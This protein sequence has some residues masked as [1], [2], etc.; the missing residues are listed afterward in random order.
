MKLQNTFVQSRMNR[1]IDERLI[2]KG[3]YINAENIRVVS[4]DGSD[5]G[6]VENIKGNEKLTT[7]GIAWATVIGA[8]IDESNNHIYYFVT[9]PTLDIVYEYNTLTDTLVRVL[10][11]TAGRE[12]DFNASNLITG[13]DVILGNTLEEKQLAWTDNLNPPRKI[14]IETAKTF[15]L[16]NFD[17]DDISTIK[18]PPSL[19]PVVCLG[20][21]VT[22]KKNRITDNFFVFS[23]SYIYEGG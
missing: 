16:D 21:D 5:V 22:I 14:Y 11:D 19:S 9:S 2:P 8:C 10:Q 6:A 23:H 7:D 17:I 13:C 18:R 12:L 1:D 15:G 20:V 4:S 3:Q